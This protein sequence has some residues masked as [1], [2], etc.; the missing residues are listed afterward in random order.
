MFPC[1]DQQ[2][3]QSRITPE[4][5]VPKNGSAGG[6]E[7]SDPLVPMGSITQVEVPMGSTT[8]AKVPVGSTTQVEVP[9][10]STT[11]VEVPVGSTTQVEVPVGSTTQVEVPVG[12]TTQVEVP[13]GSTTQSQAKVPVGSTAQE[14]M[15]RGSAPGCQSGGNVKTSHG[16]P[17]GTH[18]VGR[19]GRLLRN[20][21]CFPCQC[22]INFAASK[23]H[24]FL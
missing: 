17:V 5:W 19:H 22:H 4:V 15:P 6:Q 23:I 18:Q 3:T 2:L 9:V 14:E 16:H 10:G 12:S 20:P 7:E 24:N 8:Q 11:Q 13:V 21:C 1:T